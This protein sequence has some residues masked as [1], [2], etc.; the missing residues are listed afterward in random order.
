[1][2]RGH[3]NEEEIRS[4]SAWFSGRGVAGKERT[5]MDGERKTPARSAIAA[6]EGQRAFPPA[7]QK[8]SICILLEVFFRK[9]PMRLQHDKKSLWNE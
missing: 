2:K 4:I 1:M 5:R 8:M 6:R 9:A 7:N 3:L